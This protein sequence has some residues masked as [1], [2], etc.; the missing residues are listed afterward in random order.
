MSLPY[1]AEICMP[2]R[3]LHENFVVIYKLSLCLKNYKFLQYRNFTLS[4]LPFL[5][6]H[7]HHRHRR[8]HLLSRFFKLNNFLSAVAT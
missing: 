7:F 1:N 5:S 8:R 6:R 3:I 4:N 2:H